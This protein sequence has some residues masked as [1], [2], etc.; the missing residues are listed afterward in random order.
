MPLTRL[1]ARSAAVLL[2]TTVLGAQAQ[3]R[4][5]EWMY[6][7]SEF[8]EFTN[9]GPTA[10]DMTGWSYDDESRTAGTISLSAF[11]TV[12]VGESVILAEDDAAD[13]RAQW[14]LAGAVKVIG[15]NTANLAR[16]D[17][18][19]LF[20]AQGAL[21]DRLRYGDSS[22]VPGS[23]RTQDISGNPGSLD[24]L[25][26]DNSTGWVLSAAGDIY[27]SMASTGGQLGNP[28]QFTLAVPEPASAALLLA[29][30]GLVAG[31]ARRRA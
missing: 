26:G 6:S 13:F 11:G 15:G 25:A 23:I 12:A 5:S 27:G 2:A 18:I 7:G 9:L 8:I 14:G 4:I 19:N 21:A 24:V 10:I 31:L 1:L 3:V 16:N 29:G 20:D 30:M 17:A 28:G 22:Y